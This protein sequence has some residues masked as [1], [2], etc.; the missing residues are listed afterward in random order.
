VFGSINPVLAISDMGKFYAGG[1]RGTAWVYM[2]FHVI[3]F[4]ILFD[5]YSGNA[6]KKK[7]FVF[8]TM[9]LLAAMT[10][11]RSIYIVYFLFSVFL[12]VVVNRK[13]I[14]SIY[15]IFAA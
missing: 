7:I 14:K 6:S 4:L 1:G 5:F 15:Y 13:K 12:L 8:I 3:F 9:L 11:G 10:G 2:L